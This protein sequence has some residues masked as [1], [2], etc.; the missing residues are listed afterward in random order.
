[1]PTEASFNKHTSNLAFNNNVPN[2]LKIMK[3][4]AAQRGGGSSDAEK[5]KAFFKFAD[6]MPTLG[7]KRAALLA[8]DDAVPD[9]R[10]ASKTRKAPDDEDELETEAVQVRF[11]STRSRC[12][13]VFL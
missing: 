2:F 1:M 9:P 8:D 13:V 10:D 12:N 3:T 6:S 5:D 7:D 11:W 4:Q